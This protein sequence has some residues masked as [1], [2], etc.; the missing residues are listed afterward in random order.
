MSQL[1]R[2]SS[3]GASDPDDNLGA[4]KM[5]FG[6]DKGKRLDELDMGYRLVLAGYASE[7][8]NPDVSTFL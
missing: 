2:G 3:G 8:P 1:E 7:N 6:K 4:T 5:W